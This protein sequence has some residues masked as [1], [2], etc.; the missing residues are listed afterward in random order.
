MDTQSTQT[1][2]LPILQPENGN[3][4]TVTKT[5]DDKETVIPPISVKEKAQRKAELKARSTLLMA[6]PNEHLLKFNSYKDAKTLM[7]AIENRFGGN[8]ITKKTQKNIL[9]Q[10]YENFVESRT[11]RNKPEIETLSLDDLF[12]NLKAYKSEVKGTSSSTTNSH[13][14]GFLSSSNTNRAV[15]TAHGV[16]TASTQGAANS[17]TTVENLSDAV[18]YSFFASQPRIPQLDNKDLQQSNPD[19]LEEMNLR[20][21]IAMLTM[22]ARRFL[23]N[24]GRKL[25]MDNKERIRF[26]KFH[27]VGVFQLPQERTLCK[28]YLS[29]RRYMAMNAERPKQNEVQ[30][31]LL[32]WLILQQFNFICPHSEKSV[33][34][35]CLVF[36]KNE[37]VYEEDIKLLKREIYL[38]DLNITEIKR[39]LELAIKEK[40]EVQLTVQKFENSSK[41]LS[42]LLDRQIMDKCK[43][44][45]G[46][47]ADVCVDRASNDFVDVNESVSKSV[48]EKPTLETNELETSRKENEALSIEDWVSDSD[49]ENV[50]KV[51]TVEMFNKPTN[52]KD[53]GV[54]DSGCTRHMTGNRSYLTDEGRNYRGFACLGVIP[55][56]MENL[57]E[58]GIKP[59]LS[60][61]R[62]FGC[63]VTILNTI[64]HLGSGPNWLFDI[65]ALTNS[66][67]YKPVVTGN[68]SNGNASTK[69]C[70]DAGKARIEKI[71]GKDYILLPMWPADLLFSQDSKS[72]P[73]AGFKPSGEE[74]KKDAKDP[75]NESGNPTEG[76]DS[77]VP[78]TEEPRI[79]QEKDD[80]INSTNNINTASDGNIT[81]NVNA[82]SLT[83]NTA[84][85]EV[86]VVDP[87]TSI[88]LPNDP[89]MPELED[90]VY[91]DDEEDVGVEADINN[92]DTFMHVSP[93]TTTR[94]HK[95]HPI[96]QIIGDLNSAPQT[97]RMTKNVTE[98]AMFSSVQQRTNH[99]D[100]QNSLFACF[101]SQEAPTKV[102]TLMDLPN[103]K[104]AIGTKWVYRNKKYERGIVIKNKARLVAQGY[105]QEEGID[106]DEV[107]APVARIEAI[108]LFL[109]YASFKDFVVYQMDV[110]I[111]FLYGKI[112]EEVYV[113]Q[114]PGFED[115]D[116]LNRVYKVEKALYGLHQ[117]PKA[118][119][120]TLSTYLL[121]NRFQRGKID[122][123]LFIRRVKSDILL[124]Q[125]YVDD[126]IFG[127][128]KKS[129][130]TEFEKMM[131]K[132]FQMSS[133]G[134]L[135]FFLGLQV[136]QKEDG[137]F[138]SQD[139]YVT[140]ILN[141]FGFTDVKTASTPMETQKPLLKDA[142]GEDVNE[143]LYRSMIGSLMYLTSLRPDIMFAYPKDLPFDLVENA[144]SDYAGASLDRKS[145]IGDFNICLQVL[146]CLTSE[147]LIKGRL[148]V[149]MCSGLY[150]NDD[151]NGMQKLLRMEI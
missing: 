82:V 20:W 140:E 11:E 63:P 108:R 133:M 76:K 88:E 115:L 62:P 15:N 60:F 144:D 125:V 31:I 7:Q 129:L 46:Y 64:D 47:N 58:N 119:Y 80:N 123:T 55:K 6:L 40:D 72:S 21:N 1:I 138:I 14:V 9:K 23:K 68:Q 139:K 121:D 91:S 67:N 127:S 42:K 24:T 130:C 109:A 36:K 102:W 136:K 65:D 70:N 111:A 128:T 92:I 16:N 79:N 78:S 71:S 57:L 27:K 117:A 18:I 49:E 56:G 69:A 34:A 44:G 142:D 45:L 148:I 147:V 150:T 2:K 59:A 19:D 33:E 10:Q 98:H 146:E 73:D 101:L 106:Y 132:K 3:A 141:K 89:N 17:S 94:I 137:I 12:N 30:P 81:N 151:W 143:H 122:K 104:R 50:P 28:G 83:V 37:S 124:V 41:N 100:F 32:L 135:T 22:R 120:E 84:G 126:I 35:R 113:C 99:K 93:I 134:E 5:V 85:S 74:E 131:H 53:K 95:D 51:K 61:M 54:I 112:E 87:K 145:T 29:V 43:T 103:G 107:F 26:D 39:K 90:I 13:N 75:G 8:V 105:T 25:D 96:E 4:P 52:L 118:W 38:R 77:E 114:P 116:F 66:M 86:N 149:L 110:K 97:R 48:V